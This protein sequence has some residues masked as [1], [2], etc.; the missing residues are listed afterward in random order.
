MNIKT[1]QHPSSQL[2]YST[3]ALGCSN[4]DVHSAAHMHKEPSKGTFNVGAQVDR[5]LV[6]HASE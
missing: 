1:E 2:S 3:S 5:D 4:H 6:E